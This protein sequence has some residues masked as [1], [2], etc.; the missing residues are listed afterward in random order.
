[1]RVSF[2]NL[3]SHNYYG[4]LLRMFSLADSHAVPDDFFYKRTV[5]AQIILKPSSQPGGLV[6]SFVSNS[7]ICWLDL[8]L[9]LLAFLQNEKHF[10]INE[11]K[12]KV[13]FLRF[14]SLQCGH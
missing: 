10:K 11:N 2:T 13:R 12:P 5:Y 14:S 9:F 1:M 4:L 3:F 7:Y 6:V 8:G